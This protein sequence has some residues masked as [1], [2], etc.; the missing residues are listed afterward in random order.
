M[1]EIPHCV[2]VNHDTQNLCFEIRV[3]CFGIECSLSFSFYDVRP[4]SCLFHH[5]L[6]LVSQDFLLNNFLSHLLSPHF[7]IAL[8]YDRLKSL[9]QVLTYL[10]PYAET[11]HQVSSI[12][13]TVIIEEDLSVTDNKTVWVLSSA[14][15]L[16]YES[17]Q[18]LQIFCI[19]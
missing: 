8:I 5:L 4:F 9:D 14:Q 7:I 18:L 19:L 1:H 15:V 6:V 17:A 16:F 11:M 2:L 10:L 13:S 12:V 3:L